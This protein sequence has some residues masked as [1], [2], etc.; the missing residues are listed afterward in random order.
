MACLSSK[1][2]RNKIRWLPIIDV[3]NVTELTS[4]YREQLCG[5]ALMDALVELERECPIDKTGKQVMM[6]EKSLHYA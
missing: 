5:I 3:L 6:K 4:G 1:E 2:Q